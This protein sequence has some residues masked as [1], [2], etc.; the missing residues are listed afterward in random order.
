M[1]KT[2]ITFS[3]DESALNHA[4]AYAARAGVPLNRI[5]GRMLATLGE[6]EPTG[7]TMNTAQRQLLRYSVGR[8]SLSETVQALQVNDGGV[9]FALLRELGL[10]FPLMDVEAA[11][12]QVD[13][14]LPALRGALKEPA[15][16]RARAPKRG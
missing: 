3:V 2:N 8:A 15:Q 4:K 11:Q 7:V 10:P 14:V 1:S 5:V 12:Q 9:V 13:Q 6:A 16:V